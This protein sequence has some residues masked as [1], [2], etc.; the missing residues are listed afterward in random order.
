MQELLKSMTGRDYQKIF[1]RRKD[2]RRLST[3]EYK[4]MTDEQL[5]ESMLEAEHQANR[6]LQ[7][8]PVV[9]KRSDV[10]TV[11]SRDPAL[12][13]YRNSKF[14]FTDI[15]FGI[16]NHDRLIA[17]REPDGTLR[18]ANW[19]ERH[20]MNQIYFPVEGRNMTM[21]QMFEKEHLE[22]TINATNVIQNIFFVLIFLYILTQSLCQFCKLKLHLYF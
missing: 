4:F 22:V 11:L 9:K 5:K 3:P 10:T 7:M 20:R 18:H 21:P 2:N 6:L 16:E 14:V 13:G 17:V 12:Q 8:P 15:T 19:D 1:R